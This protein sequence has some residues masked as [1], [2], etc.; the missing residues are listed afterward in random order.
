MSFLIVKRLTNTDMKSLFKN[1][2]F[3]TRVKLAVMALC[4]IAFSHTVQAQQNDKQAVVVASPS[5]LNT[6]DR[7]NADFPG[8]MDKFYTYISSQLALDATCIPGKKI[9][10]SFMID[11]QGKLCRAKVHGH[12]LS[13]KMNTQ[14]VKIF[15][16]APQWI[17]AQQNGLNVKEHF[18]CPINFMPKPDMM[19]VN[20]SAIK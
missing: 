8:G 13:D 5:S 11:K 17:P 3:K 20:N 15:E 19:A 6:E 1:F 4:T 16:S 14:L 12:L 10:V 18:V 9:D 2:S 7:V